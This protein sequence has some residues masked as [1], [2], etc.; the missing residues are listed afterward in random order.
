MKTSA[1]LAIAASTVATVASAELLK[2][3]APISSTVWTAGSDATISWTNDCADQATTTF[4][5]MLQTQ[6]AD[7]V[8]IPVAGLASLGDL[9]CAKA[10]SLTVQ[11]PATV[12][13]GKLYSILVTNGNQSYS[14]LFTIQNAAIPDP[15]A[16]VTTTASGVPTST[17][18]PTGTSTVNGTASATKPSVTAPTTST[19]TTPN[20][21]GALKTGSVAA[22]A[23]A[24][25]VAAFIF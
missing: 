2:Y 4:P 23:V 24:A 11:V 17:A 14:A 18:L 22:L 13:S 6:R 5:V 7:G 25:A 8:Q 16:N 19:T 1:I 3:G 15:S 9:D 21:A 20:N 12:P 10:G